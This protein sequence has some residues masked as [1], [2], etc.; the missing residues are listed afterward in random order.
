MLI[1]M[2]ELLFQIILSLT[3]FMNISHIDIFSLV[4]SSTPE[5]KPVSKSTS[6]GANFGTIEA[7]AAA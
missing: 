5:A 1:F 2:Y 3:F 6:S 7:A 4:H